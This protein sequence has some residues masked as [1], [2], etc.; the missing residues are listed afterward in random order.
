MSEYSILDNHSMLAL[1]EDVQSTFKSYNV[2]FSA[3]HDFNKVYQD[4]DLF[5]KYV[6]GLSQGLDEDDVRTFSVLSNNIKNFMTLNE[7]N[8]TTSI[9][10]IPQAKVLLPLFRFMWP[11]LIMKELVTTMAIDNPELVRYF[12]K[13]TATNPD[14]TEVNLPSYQ[15]LGMGMSIGSWSVPHMVSVP[16]TT[17][18]LAVVGLTPATASLERKV[19]ITRWEGVDNA[20][21][22]T[23]GDVSVVATEEGQFQFTAQ[24]DTGTVDI[25]TGVID[26]VKGTINAS[27]TRS[28]NTNGKVTSIGLVASASTAENNISTSIGF[29]VDKLRFFSRDLELQAK[30]TIQ[31]EQDY[32]AR[33]GL[34]IQAEFVSVFGNQT[35]LTWDLLLFNDIMFKTN[36]HNPGNIVEF[37]RT[38]TR[39]GFAHTIKSWAEELLFKIESVSAQ[40][41]NDTSLMPATHLVCNPSDLVWLK[42]LNQFDFK[43]GYNKNGQYG[44]SPVAGTL[45]DGMTVLCSP[46]V[47]KNY[48]LIGAKPTQESFAN[49][50]FMPYIPMTMIPYPLGNKPAMTFLSRFGYEMIRPEGF[51]LIKLIG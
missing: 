3:I 39:T 30:W 41:Y 25:V 13:P 24:V 20:G 38:P 49:Y 19:V 10:F 31:G 12:F 43:G 6:E 37:S 2:D 16:A 4:D 47:P 8:T 35:Q 7:V 26:Y 11:R 44:S 14:G 28:T 50:V 17:D 42:M 23:H 15:P 40:I 36:K 45:S 1:M 46:I 33:V 9:G 5:S 21:A 51:G 18:L 34:D 22:A 27:G 32:R 48:M 29:K